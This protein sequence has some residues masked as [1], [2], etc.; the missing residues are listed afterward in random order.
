VSIWIIWFIWSDDITCGPSNMGNHSFCST[1]L[2]AYF[3][4]QSH[5]WEANRFSASTEIPRIL[6][7]PN[8]LYRIHKCLGLPTGL[9]PL[10]FPTKTLCTPLSSPIHTTC[11]AHPISILSPEQYRARST[12]NKAPQFSPLPCYF[13][14]L[15]P[16][17]SPQHPILT[18]LLL[19]NQHNYSSVYRN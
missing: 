14:P 1:I 18:F 17:Y 8:V 6:W 11:P 4:E 10:G 13:V 12:D 15:R 9:F 2:T 3:M 7:N 16:I 5:S 19:Y